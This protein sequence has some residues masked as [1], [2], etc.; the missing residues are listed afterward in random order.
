MS[1]KAAAAAAR[2]HHKRKS[3]DA[4]V[5]HSNKSKATK[6]KPTLVVSA[7]T[8]R[9]SLHAEIGYS[10]Y[11][12]QDIH[13]M[14]QALCRRLPHVPENGFLLLPPE[15]QQQQDDT[16]AKQPTTTTTPTTPTTATTVT[17]TTTPSTL[18][19]PKQ[20]CPYD[21]TQLRAW[22]TAVQTV[23]EEFHLLVACVSPATYVWGTD[24]SGAADQ[25]LSLLSGELVRSQEQILARV[26]PRLNDVLAPVVTL[27]TDKTETRKRP[28]DGMEVKQNFFVTTQEDPDY[29]D[30][31]YTILARN[32]PLLRQVVLANFD[33]LLQAMEDY[34]TAQR[35]D[36]SHD[37]RGFVY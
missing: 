24:R 36:A 11:N 25:N 7:T 17:T 5:H 37:S 22:A 19:Q 27:V 9:L 6:K 13:D 3:D 14:I 33:K 35:K 16:A 1:S 31:C 21:K 2:S 26:T 10:P 15:Q 34:L 20:P 18:P 8:D 30:L 29:A 12:L 4:N 23:L 28:Q 32:A